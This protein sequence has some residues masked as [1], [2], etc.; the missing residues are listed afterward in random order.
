[1]RLGED[2][3]P[4]SRCSGPCFSRT[5]EICERLS[6][7]M[8]R[9]CV[10]TGSSV[11]TLLSYFSYAYA[12]EYDVL[13]QF[14]A[15]GEHVASELPKLMSPIL[16][17]QADISIGSR[18]IERAGFQSTST[19]RVGIWLFSS[20]FT[21]VTG[22]RVTDIT[23]GFRAYNRDV[24]KFF[25]HTY[26]DPVYDSMNQFLL[27]AAFSGLRICE[28]PTLMQPRQFGKS[29]FNFWNSVMFPAKGM[30]TYI[31]C[32]LQ[33]ERIRR[34]RSNVGVVPSNP[35]ADGAAESPGGNSVMD[36]LP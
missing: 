11:G 12:G 3:S 18:F 25:G 9:H 28:I 21:W 6:V 22:S 31:S 33:R 36:I 10:N 27:L 13:C 35:F 16:V 17:N 34:L 4:S 32:L 30:M 7:R 24:I 15:D 2:Y 29:E 8:V 1:M 19:R 26:R 5:A 23:S 14:D 20:L